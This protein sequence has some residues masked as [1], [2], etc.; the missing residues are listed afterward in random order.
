MRTCALLLVLLSA[1]PYARAACVTAASA[2]T[3]TP[4]PAQTAPFTATFTA[5]PSA[6]RID[7]VAGLAATTASDWSR[8]AAIVRFNT[9]GQ[10]DARNAGAYAAVTSVPYAA[11][12]SYKFRLTVNPSTKRYNVYVTPPGS[13]E[14]TLAYDYAFRTEQASVSSLAYWAA[15]ADGGSLQVCDF[16]V[17]GATAGT[18]T[19]TAPAT[20]CKNG[21]T[22]WQ[23]TSITPQLAA[24][25]A[26]YEVT[27]GAARLDGVTGLSQGAAADFTK[28]AA[29]VRFNNAG[30]IDA[31]NGGAYAAASSTPYTAGLKYR[32]RVHADPVSKRYHAWAAPPGS[33]ERKIAENYAFRTEQNAV[34]RLDNWA[35]RSDGGALQVCGF[36]TAP[37]GPITAT[38][39]APAPVPAGGDKW[40]IKQLYPSAAGGKN[41]VSK[42]DNGSPR[43]FRGVDPLDP[44]FDANHGDASYSVDGQGLFKITGPVP[45]MYVHDPTNNVASSWRNV[46]ITLYAMRVADAGTAWGGIVCLGRTNHGT[47]G[48]ETSNL[49]DTRG[50]GA[51][52]RYDGKVDFEKETSHPISQVAA[53]KSYWSGSLPRNQW[54]GYKH[55]I[56]DLPDGNVKQELWLD[57]SDGASGG[58]W[59]KINEF[60]DTGSNFGTAGRACKSGVAPGLRLTNSD[61]RP[62]SE[63]GKPNITVYCRSDDVGANGLIYKKMS[64]RE[65]AP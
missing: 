3:N 30:T 12:A 47:T 5:V 55:V 28:L 23:N 56:Y 49:C 39:P 57:E 16:A 4:L 44:W 33:S 54:L 52:M 22:A 36:G 41:W 27:P 29:V 18:G 15:K 13:A 37:A 8:L 24:F 61:S 38:A 45:R 43:S 7:G 25:T 59:K 31:R 65:I 1:S 42:W 6:A 46:E 48:S 50:L 60:T 64:V 21:S 35:V 2:W 62:G 9:S 63:S 53:S 14:R 10:I 26:T 20:G 51:R 32:I 11:G 19:T 58:A 34:T 17:A 40:G